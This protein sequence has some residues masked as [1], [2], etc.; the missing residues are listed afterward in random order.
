M[1]NYKI[2]YFVISVNEDDISV[3]IRDDFGSIRHSINPTMVTLMYVKVNTIQIG[4]KTST[5]P[6]VLDF[7]SNYDAKIGLVEL[8]IEMDKILNRVKNEE[9]KKEESL[10]QLETGVD[11]LSIY[12]GVTQS[13]S[14]SSIANKTIDER[15]TDLVS[16]LSDD[17][18]S[19]KEQKNIQ[20]SL[21]PIGSWGVDVNEHVDIL[22]LSFSEKSDGIPNVYINGVHLT[23]GT[24]SQS[25]SYLSDGVSVS[26][27]INVGSKIYLNPYLLDYEID[28]TDVITIHYLTY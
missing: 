15:I 25:I 20:I 18:Y 4:S 17:F 23:I 19:L 1:A 14:T 16:K 26:N 10:K 11:F 3:K 22:G 21:N 24:N 2:G 8:R 13:G 28:E 6:I 27:V 9:I 12:E 5:E 7:K